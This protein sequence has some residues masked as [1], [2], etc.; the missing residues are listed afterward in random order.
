MQ[1][2]LLFSVPKATRHLSEADRTLAKLIEQHGPY[3]PRIRTS[4]HYGTL[5]SSILGQQ[6]SGKAARTIRRRFFA[7]Y[8]S[9]ETPPTPEQILK[10][11]APQFRAVGVSA[12]KRGYL[13][14]LARHVA[15]GRT[16]FSVI[17]TLPDDEIMAHL[18][19]IKGIGE[20]TVHM[21]LMFHLGRPD[22]LP[23]GDLG[24]RKG[25]VSAY[26]LRKLPSPRRMHEI[27]KP[28]EPYRSVGSWYMWR[29]ADTDMGV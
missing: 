24:V 13:K 18:T 8:G 17:H 27:A 2:R 9:E 7:L 14:D 28:W 4:D 10:T 6:L 29:V 11:R 20:W 19:A 21:F 12:H 15:D 3:T 26:E 1:K 22:I 16:D 25:M 23:T 5:V